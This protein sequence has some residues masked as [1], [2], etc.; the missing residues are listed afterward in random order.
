[1][2]VTLHIDGQPVTLENVARKAQEIS[3]VLGGK[4]YQFRSLSLPDGSFLLEREIAPG[5]WQRMSGASW[6]GNKNMRHVQVG[7]LEAKISELAKGAAQT[8]AEAALSPT[9]P[10]PGLIR[11]I[12]V[13][14][15][16]KVARN[17]PLLVMEAMKLQTTL[18][19]GGDATVE[20]V[21][22]KEG[23]LV[24]DGAE[25]VKLKAAS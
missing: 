7:A 1:M 21:L 15:G 5:V 2:N 23:D 25:L 9:A 16:D 17:Q 4:T 6:Q 19:A 13:K 10:M 12:L 22:V 20:A 11:Q 24:T 18:S 14:A 3:F 8:S